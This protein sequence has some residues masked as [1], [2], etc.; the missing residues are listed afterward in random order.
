MKTLKG[1]HFIQK[2]HPELLKDESSLSGGN[3]QYAA[4]PVDS[5]EAADFI[6]EC[7]E[8][9][10]Q[11]TV[12]GARTGIAGGAVP[13]GGAVL[14][15]ERLLGIHETENRSRIRVMC[16]ETLDSVEEYC[17]L[18]KPGY[19]YPPDPTE[20]T[21]SIGGTIATDAS[22]SSSYMYG[23]TRKWIDG[24][25]VILPRGKLLEIR[26]GDHRFTHGR[27]M[28][29]EL[30]LLVLPAL[31]KPQPP[32]NAAGLYIRPDM[33]LIDLFIGSEGEL[34]LISSAELI[35]ARKPHAVA[36]LAIFCEEEQF[37]D[38][39]SDLT[40]TTLPVR[41]LEAMVPPC[42][43][44]LAGNTH[45]TDHPPGDWVIIT[46]IE[47]YSEDDLDQVLETLSVMLEERGISPDNTWGGFDENERKKLKEF[48]HL[49]PE[50]I[51]RLISGLSMKNHSIHKI[52]SDTAV[53]PA[54]LREYHNYM[55]KV[56]KETQV[57]HVVFG[58]CGQGHLHAN[59][60]PENRKELEASEKA[61]ELLAKRAV[62]LGGTVS[63]EHGTGRL[64]KHFLK[65][66]YSQN[67]LEE[68]ELLKSA[69]RSI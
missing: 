20:T 68:T 64:K 6:R 27:L 59:L 39:R 19:F 21:A 50:T 49:L 1:T 52:S 14:S 30:G 13:M 63:A 8:D 56:L 2:E 35:L 28:H 7:S 3:C 26:R 24:I 37:W 42:L 47:A 65:L 43:E 22:G 10:V 40:N 41:E 29:P 34:G 69:I 33:D 61:V 66:M 25:E 15:T 18:N 38:L 32:K 48:R 45:Q 55:S 67:E 12:S 4:W 5:N 31:S 9:R 17:R 16:G 44:F 46:S 54:E 57:E 11:L 53:S 23:S 60:I 58:H 36:T 62:L 51:N